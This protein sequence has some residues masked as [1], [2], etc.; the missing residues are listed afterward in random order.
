MVPFSFTHTLS[1]DSTE[2]R[3]MKAAAFS[4]AKALPVF[5]I[6][7]S[8]QFLSHCKHFFQHTYITGLF[9]LPEPELLD[10]RNNHTCSS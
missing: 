7:L 1:G 10:G 5:L 8:S 6:Q 3:E 2:S 4:G 9:L